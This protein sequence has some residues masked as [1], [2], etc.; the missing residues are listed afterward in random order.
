MGE[1]DLERLRAVSKEVNK[2]RI[3]LKREYFKARLTE[4]VGDLK[5]TW[6]VLGEVLTG[7]R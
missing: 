7:R 4:K 1:D 5:A 6:E 2:M 3:K